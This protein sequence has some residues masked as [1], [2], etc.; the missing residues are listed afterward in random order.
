[1]FKP[2]PPFFILTEKVKKKAIKEGWPKV[3]D[4]QCGQI[5]YVDPKENLYIEYKC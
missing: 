4:Y 1:M 3:R 2:K 5:A